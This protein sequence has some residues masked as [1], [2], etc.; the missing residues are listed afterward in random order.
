[1]DRPTD[2]REGDLTAGRELVEVNAGSLTSPVLIGRQRELDLLVRALTNPPSV[3]LVE[4]EAGIGK[5]RLLQEALGDAGARTGRSILVGHCRPVLDPFPLAPVLE[6]LRGASHGLPR[7]LN[8]VA[9]AL[10]PLLPEV[11]ER[12]PPVPEALEDAQAEQ[13]RVFRAIEEIVRALGP[14]ILV[15]EDLHWVDE[16]TAEL[17]RFLSSDF[18]TELS[19][20][21]TYR[22]ADAPQRA[23]IVG[24]ASRLRGK[25]LVRIRLESLGP[26]AVGELVSAILDDAEVSPEFASYLYDRTAGVP[27]AIEEVVRLLRERDHIVRHQ[28]RW[29]RRALEDLEVPLGIQAS[30]AERMARLSRSSQ[31]LVQ[32]AAVLRVRSSLSLLAAVG[33]VK[34]TEAVSA[35]TEALRSALLVEHEQGTFGL[36][37]AL[38]RQAVYED[39]EG[40]LRRSLHL[41]AARASDSADDRLVGEIANHFREAGY[42][43]EWARWAERAADVA[44]S[45]GDD[46]TASSYLRDALGIP[47]LSHARRARLAVKFGR[48]ALQ[49][50]AHQEGVQIL[51]RILEEEELPPGVRGEMRHS[52]A[53]LLDQAGDA[54]GGLEELRRALPDV[55]RRPELRARVMASLAWLW[56]PSGH[57][58][59]HLVWMQRAADASED[60]K[61]PVIRTAI[62]VDRALILVALGDPEGWR[63]VVELPQEG[64]SVGVRRQLQRA[65]VNLSSVC[66]FLG[67]YGPAEL[68]LQRSERMSEE[69]SYLKDSGVIEGTR[70]MLDWAAGRWKGLADRAR[71]ALDL[72]EDVPH[73]QADAQVVLG[74]VLLAA[75]RLSDAEE[76]LGSSI[77]LALAAGTLNTL[78]IAAAALGRIRLAQEDP[79]GA[80]DSAEL[81]LAIA[82]RK[83]IWIWGSEPAVVAVEALCRLG[84]TDEAANI[85]DALSKALRGHAAPEPEVARALCRALLA[86]KSGRN[87]DAARLLAQAVRRLKAF[88]H[89]YRAALAQESR[90]I[91]LLAHGNPRWED[92]TKEALE[93]FR[94]LGASWDSARVLKTLREQGSVP[95]YRGGRRGYGNRLSPREEE[96]ARLA[97]EGRTNQEIATALFLSPRT[98][99]RHMAGAM[100]KLGVSSRKALRVPVGADQD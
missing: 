29:A 62:K 75:G 92:S 48:A 56:V 13:H 79:Q 5:T 40:P 4:G 68:F 78:Q 77:D 9:G 65:Y 41:R 20:I 82:R 38:A 23:P 27:F 8:P 42:Q 16:K 60:V 94:D 61:D 49:G 44:V 55:R 69:L 26:R 3:V 19:L 58:S 80:L 89:P 51:R 59:D 47:G 33:G 36:R 14:S 32:A 12:L 43:R 24:L 66:F 39:I 73:A 91:A 30:I 54:E 10:R 100:Q 31:A 18:P 88:P 22:G 67:N 25:E 74:L 72:A 83:G 63:A 11:A 1:M 87:A 17:L 35:L 93:T 96:V 28:G 76:A 57:V 2:S 70:L 85:S 6:A 21:L 50:F 52:L 46:T 90:G 34:P 99:E 71:R 37:H 86:E 64:A 98:V 84:R 97:S 7:Q 53:Q 15:L 95:T 81:G 45:L